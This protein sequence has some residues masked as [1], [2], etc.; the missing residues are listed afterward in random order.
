MPDA[1][2]RLLLTKCDHGRRVSTRNDRED[3]HGIVDT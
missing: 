1:M 3:V 2:G